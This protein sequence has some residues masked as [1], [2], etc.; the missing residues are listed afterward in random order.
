[1]APAGISAL[2]HAGLPGEL[3]LSLDAPEAERRR[4]LADWLTDPRNPLTA[5]VM[6]N[7][8]WYYHF[9]QGL[10]DTPSDFGF[11]GGR[12]SHPELLDWLADE[13]VHSGWNLRHLHKLILLS[14]TYR[15]RSRVDNAQADRI[16]ADNRLYWRANR[17]RLEGEA[18]RDAVLFTS[19]A[20]NPQLGG[21]SFHDVTA[22]R[23]EKSKNDEFT[24]PT[25]DFTDDT[26]RRSIYRLWARSGGH[27]LMD[28]LD[29]PD[30]TVAVPR[31]AQTITPLQALSLLNNPFTE[32]CARR[33]AARIQ[34]EITTDDRP[35]QV[36]RAFQLTLQRLPT[37]RELGLI[38]PF[39][40]E[41]GLEQVCL[42]LFNGNEF[43]YVD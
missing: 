21:P 2:E 12:P 41:Y 9:G 13:F 43:L 17:R 8:L 30:P 26:C 32:H 14:S 27:P 28:A 18:I 25:N 22:T 29:C 1:V 33:A 19:G 24:T 15:Q 3:G 11:S 20:L 42:T 38:I 35:G 10:V 31:R 6:V 40:R 36:N 39:A 37:E 23:N 4:K 16:D 5:R 7:R 34:A